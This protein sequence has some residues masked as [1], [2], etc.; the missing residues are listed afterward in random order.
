[1]RMIAMT[2]ALALLMTPAHAD[3]ASVAEGMFAASLYD[4]DCAKLPP[5]KMASIKT[6][7][8]EINRDVMLA[9]IKRVGDYYR[10]VGT[11]AFCAEWKVKIEGASK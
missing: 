6:L 10:S 1:M 4:R 7:L 2:T 11:A 5:A 9:A 3:D 8:G